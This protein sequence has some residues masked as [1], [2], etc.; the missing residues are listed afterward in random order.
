[1]NYESCSLYSEN[2]ASWLVGK[3]FREK[4]VRFVCHHPINVRL[5]SLVIAM[6]CFIP[7]SILTPSLLVSTCVD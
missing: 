7:S 4:C 6:A 3:E 2:N 1:M 5:N